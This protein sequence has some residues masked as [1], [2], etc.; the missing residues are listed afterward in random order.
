MESVGVINL[1][2]INVKIYIILLYISSFVING[3]INSA[4]CNYTLF[5]KITL[6][7]KGPNS[8]CLV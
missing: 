3:T 4:S 1:K 2:F 8:I 7:I 5:Q 6:P